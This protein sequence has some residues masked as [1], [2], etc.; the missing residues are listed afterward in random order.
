MQ[1]NINL[2]SRQNDLV[3]QELP[4]E[5]LIYDLKTNKA[6]CFNHT[7]AFVWQHAD[8]ETNVGQMAYL[9]QKKLRTSVDE[10][11]I[12]FALERLEKDG[13]LANK[14]QAPQM[15]AGMTSQDSR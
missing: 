15:F 6:F 8:G 7:A 11:V 13:L 12:W 3:V 4:D 1:L 5:V 10:S 14:T 9:L 2:K